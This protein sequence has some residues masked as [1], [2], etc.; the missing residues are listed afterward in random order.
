MLTYKK[1]LIIV[2]VIGLSISVSKAHITPMVH[3]VKHNEAIKSILTEAQSFYVKTIPLGNEE[4]NKIEFVL[5]ELHNTKIYKFYYG[6]DAQGQIVGDV[7]FINVHSK[8]G[9]VTLA[10]GFTPE[11]EIIKVVVTDVPVEPL[12]WVRKLLAVNFLDQFSGKSSVNIEESLKTLSRTKIG[13]MSYYF[14]RKISAGVRQTV[15][16]QKALFHKK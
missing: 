6:K 7:L 3:M 9:P 16:L 15:I 4:K 5:P 11:D 14:A 2:L 10:V 12:P 13:A 1:V 8:H